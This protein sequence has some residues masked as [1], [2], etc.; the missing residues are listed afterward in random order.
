MATEYAYDISLSADKK[1]L[2]LTVELPKREFAREPIL[3]CTDAN[4]LDIIKQGGFGNYEQVKGGGTLSNWVSR[5]G[6]GG[7]RAG[8]WIFEKNP[9]KKTAAKKTAA[10]KTT[11]KTTATS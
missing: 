3:E 5:E 1:H 9:P 7:D 8:T 4:A 11:K 6:R 10:K 2:T